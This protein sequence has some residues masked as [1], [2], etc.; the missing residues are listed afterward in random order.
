MK[1]F[2][3][4][5]ENY[6]GGGKNVWEKYFEVFEEPSR[7]ELKDIGVVIRAII[8]PNKMYIWGGYDGF[9]GDAMKII[10]SFNKK[11]MVNV[12]GKVSGRTLKMNLS[13]AAMIG[14]VDWNTKNG[15]YEMSDIN[16]MLHKHK[17]LNRTFPNW[18]IN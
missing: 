8:I 10:G 6:V 2:K 17:Y 4:L 13:M 12:T 1:T 15:T 18:S 9:H 14:V 5:R 11:K 3:Q 7:S 16:E